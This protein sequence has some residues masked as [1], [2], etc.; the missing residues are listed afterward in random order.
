MVAICDHLEGL[1]V[2]SG[3]QRYA[4]VGG[5]AAEGKGEIAASRLALLAMTA[6]GAPAPRGERLRR[7]R[8]LPRRPWCRLREGRLI[9]GWPFTRG[10]GASPAILG[11][12]AG[13]G[14]SNRSCH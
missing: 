9:G 6:L 7:Q 13:G 3:W 14:A 12:V 2:L 8:R 1:K 10:A 4:A 11:K 5:R